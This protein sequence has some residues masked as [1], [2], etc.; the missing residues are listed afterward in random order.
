MQVSLWPLFLLCLLS[1]GIH[2]VQKFRPHLAQTAGF[3]R[4]LN[5][6]I[7]PAHLSAMAALECGAWGRWSQGSTEYA[8]YTE[9]DY[10]A[11]FTERGRCI[12]RQLCIRDQL[13]LL[14]S[15]LALESG[16]SPPCRSHTTRRSTS[17]RHGWRVSHY[18][19]IL[20]Q[21]MQIGD[22]TALCSP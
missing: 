3:S 11:T 13:L 8:I 12:R 10:G 5:L 16:A 15:L 21:Q 7:Q 4:N 22:Q 1:L 17:Q 9:K 18:P 19:A 20:Q 14:A 2:R 6:F